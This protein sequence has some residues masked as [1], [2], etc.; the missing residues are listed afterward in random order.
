MCFI[1]ELSEVVVGFHKGRK[2]FN[3]HPCQDTMLDC[4]TTVMWSK[5]KRGS[6][7]SG[8]QENSMKIIGKD[9]AKS[10]SRG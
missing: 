6:T 8:L 4:T 2:Q 10:Q 5:K 9:W 1:L 7:T 3:C